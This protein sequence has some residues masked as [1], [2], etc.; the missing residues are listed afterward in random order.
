MFR[1]LDEH[2]D[3][4]RFWLIDEDTLEEIGSC[5]SDMMVEKVREMA[6]GCK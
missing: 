3:K 5:I 2:L 4:E 6:R 1:M